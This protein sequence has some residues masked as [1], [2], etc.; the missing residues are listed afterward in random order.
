MADTTFR[1]VGRMSETGCKSHI[2]F[3]DVSVETPYPHEVQLMVLA[4]PDQ[5]CDAFIE[6]LEPASARKVEITMRLDGGSLVCWTDDLKV[7]EA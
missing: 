2:H 7:V 3:Y 4:R 1:I 5:D 6:A